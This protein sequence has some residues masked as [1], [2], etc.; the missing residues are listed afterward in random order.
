MMCQADGNEAEESY[1]GCS[2]TNIGFHTV[3]AGVACYGVPRYAYPHQS[4]PNSGVIVP[5]NTEAQ[6]LLQVGTSHSIFPRPPRS[7]VH[8]QPMPVRAWINKHAH[9]LMAPSHL[10]GMH[11]AAR[12]HQTGGPDKML[13]ADRAG[14]S[15]VQ[16]AR[17]YVL[18]WRGASCAWQMPFAREM[19]SSTTYYI[20]SG[21]E[22]K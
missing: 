22:A 10:R 13:A 18:A 14:S 15:D 6:Q 2:L 19:S 3:S 12:S 16:Y 4:T 17:I 21:V 20:P 7:F 1:H 9:N 11:L 5:I 8:G